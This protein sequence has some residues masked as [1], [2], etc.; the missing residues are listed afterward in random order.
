MKDA[1]DS[2]KYNGYAPS[3]GKLP[4]R[5]YLVASK[6]LVIFQEEYVSSNPPCFP[7]AQFLRG[8]QAKWPLGFGESGLV[9]LTHK[10]Q[11]PAS[12]LAFF[13]IL[14]SALE[15]PTTYLRLN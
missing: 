12:F 7:D 14:P 13:G 5:L 8:G 2:G 1:L 6:P 3:I 9:M 10:L 11:G 4:L 15:A